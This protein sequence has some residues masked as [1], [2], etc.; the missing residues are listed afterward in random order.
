MRLPVGSCYAC[1][2]GC[3]MR[4][5]AAGAA[6]SGRRKAAGAAASGRRKAAGAAASGQRDVVVT[7]PRTIVKR[8]VVLISL[9]NGIGAAQVSLSFRVNAAGEVRKIT[10]LAEYTA[11]D[12]QHPSD[13]R[14]YRKY[15]ASTEYARTSEYERTPT[16]E[17]KLIASYREEVEGVRTL[18]RNKLARIIRTWEGNVDYLVIGGTHRLSCYSKEVYARPRL[19]QLRLR[20]LRPLLCSRDRL[21]VP[22][23]FLFQGCDD[24]SEPPSGAL[25]LP[26]PSRHAPVW[27]RRFR[28]RKRRVDAVRF[29]DMMTL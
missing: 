26:A 8:K 17:R 20:S 1:D 16:G 27:S 18:T 19:T 2:A 29:G 23:T 24:N 10:V 5:G 9:S 12:A 4:R 7:A 11:E 6:A 13:Q 28:D 25:R 14:R 3:V 22:R 21:A 15:S